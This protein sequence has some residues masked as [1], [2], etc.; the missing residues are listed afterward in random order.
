MYIEREIDVTHVLDIYIY[1]GV[2]VCTVYIDIYTERER[3]IDV[4]R[5]LNIYR[6]VCVCVYRMYVY[7]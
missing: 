7:I 3:E 6:C 5:V 4:T 1:I 2:C